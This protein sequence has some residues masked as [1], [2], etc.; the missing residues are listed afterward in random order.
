MKKSR[1][2][3]FYL[4]MLIFFGGSLG[5]FWWLR[6][7]WLA[8]ASDL[9]AYLLVGAVA[10]KIGDFKCWRLMIWW[11]PLLLLPGLDWLRILRLGE[12]YGKRKVVS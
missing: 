1:P 11:L 7:W 2:W 6:W 12:I 10:N 3:S 5:N 8:L 4:F 9:A